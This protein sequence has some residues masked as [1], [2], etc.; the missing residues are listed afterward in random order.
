MAILSE[1]LHGPGYLANRGDFGRGVDD[2]PGVTPQLRC[3]EECVRGIADVDKRH[4]SVFQD[5]QNVAA[6]GA[7][8]EQVR[9][10]HE[11]WR[12]LHDR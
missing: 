8:A 3:C 9:H 12:R 2:L 4:G 10:G 6:R 11:R 5:L 1:A 7:L